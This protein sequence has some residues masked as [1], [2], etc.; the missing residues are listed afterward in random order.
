M[1]AEQHSN[2]KPL[3]KVGGMLQSP[4]MMPFSATELQIGTIQYVLFQL[5]KPGNC[6]VLKVDIAIKIEA[7]SEYYLCH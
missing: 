6:D 4:Q 2:Q 3:A 5:Q 7:I 1:N